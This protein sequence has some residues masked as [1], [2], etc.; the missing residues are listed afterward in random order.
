M[1]IRG[2]G[3]FDWNREW[4]LPQ[5][6]PRHDDRLDARRSL[7]RLGQPR[8]PRL[9]RDP[10]RPGRRRRAALALRQVDRRGAATSSSRSARSSGRRRSTTSRTSR[11]RTAA[12]P[13]STRPTSSR[14]TAFPASTAR[15]PGCARTS[16]SATRGTTRPAGR[17]ASPSGAWSA[18]PRSTTSPRAPASPVAGRTTSARSRSSF[19][20]ASG[21]STGRSSTPTSTSA[22]TSSPSPTTATSA[23]CAPPTPISPRT[24]SNPIL[25]PQPETNEF[26]LD[27][28][29]RVHRNWELRG[30][31][32][33]DLAANANLRAGAGIT[34]GNECAEFD[35]SVS[36]RYTTSSNVP[37]ST[38]IGFAVR[39]SGV[40]HN[41]EKQWPARVCTPR[42]T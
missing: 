34:Y 21:S 40:G 19:P 17:L 37:P 35:L 36:R 9:L 2:G 16:G 13:S 5:G 28:K 6:H 31:W 15:R 8:H 10:D 27:A 1:M 25:G 30:L 26:A 24:T 29:V 3:S 20:G 7:P 12:C 32:R 39:L 38:S 22:A 23:R 41:G 42:G 11:T 18:T 33:Y 4:D 14:S